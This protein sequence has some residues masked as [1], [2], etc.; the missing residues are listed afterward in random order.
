M[1][2]HA[3][4]GK[5]CSAGPA[6]R[7]DAVVRRVEHQVAERR[8]ALVQV[9]AGVYGMYLQDLAAR[10]ERQRLARGNRPRPLAAEMAPVS[11]T[12]DE[13]P[14]NGDPSLFYRDEAGYASWLDQHPAGFVLTRCAIARI[15][16][17]LFAEA[18][19]HVADRGRGVCRVLL[20]RW[21]LTTDPLS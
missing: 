7:R 15:D 11:S 19:S 4:T 16:G 17:A 14:A 3:I 21:A 12:G 9:P 13:S 10:R 18:A 6:A 8:R 1:K 2:Q 20:E 5:S